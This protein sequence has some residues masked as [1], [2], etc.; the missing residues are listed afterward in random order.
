MENNNDNQNNNDNTKFNDFTKVK[1]DCNICNCKI[2]L[3]R[4][5]KHNSTKKHIA[6]LDKIELVYLRWLEDN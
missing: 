4:M 6:N 3:C 2:I 5:T 1:I